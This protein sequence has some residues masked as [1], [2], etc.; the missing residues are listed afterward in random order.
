MKYEHNEIVMNIQVKFFFLHYK[1]ISNN[2]V[3]NLWA[4]KKKKLCA[5]WEN[6]FLTR[7]IMMFF[8]DK[9]SISIEVFDGES[10]E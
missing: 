8:R 1:L 6:V 4:K 9:I 3:Q 2:K 7:P 5:S 10:G